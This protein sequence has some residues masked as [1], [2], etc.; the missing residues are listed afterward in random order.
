MHDAFVVNEAK[1][2]AQLISM[3]LATSSFFGKKGLDLCSHPKYKDHT[4]YDSF[5][6]VHVKSIPRQVE[7]SV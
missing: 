7:G 1:K 5:D 2:Y 3:F 4:E 6:I